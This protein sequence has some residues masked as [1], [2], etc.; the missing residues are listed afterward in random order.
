[1]YFHFSIYPLNDDSKVIYSTRPELDNSTGAPLA[2]VLNKSPRLPRGWELALSE[3]SQSERRILQVKPEFGFLHEDCQYHLPADFKDSEKEEL[4]V[5]IQLIHWYPSKEVL[6]VSTSSTQC[7]LKRT[8]EDGDGYENLREPYKTQACVCVRKVASNG[9]QGTGE[10]L[11]GS[12]TDPLELT[13]GDTAIPK[14]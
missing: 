10:M 8:V 12:M 13:L 14:G 2:V 4:S 9:V 1:M 3:M 6:T 5:D 7:I 11:F